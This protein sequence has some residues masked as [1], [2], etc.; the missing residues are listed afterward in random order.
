VSEGDAPDTIA[1]PSRLAPPR[2]SGVCPVCGSAASPP[3]HV[4]PSP[5]GS[6]LPVSAM[7]PGVDIVAVGHAR[8]M[9][10]QGGSGLARLPGRFVRSATALPLCDGHG[11]F[12]ADSREPRRAGFAR[13][14]LGE[15]PQMNRL[16]QR[17]RHGRPSAGSGWAACDRG[18]AT[19]TAI[20]PAVRGARP[21]SSGSRPRD[22]RPVLHARAWRASRRWC[23]SSP[24]C[25]AWCRR[26]RKGCRSPQAAAR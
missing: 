3:F 7:R 9:Q 1:N 10:R 12:P 18:R 22:A 25:R 11:G 2:R 13:G 23:G 15:R 21:V 4:R 24:L 17:K 20:R 5:H 16:V 8:I 14:Q 6:P 19:L 26:R